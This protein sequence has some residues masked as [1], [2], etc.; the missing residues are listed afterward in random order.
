MGNPIIDEITKQSE[1]EEGFVSRLKKD[2]NDNI[3][4]LFPG[5]RKQEIKRFLP[6]LLKTAE[7]I[8]AKDHTA[9]FLVSCSW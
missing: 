4:S 7:F 5:S 6:I 8:Y 9:I 2:C 3:I 1:Y